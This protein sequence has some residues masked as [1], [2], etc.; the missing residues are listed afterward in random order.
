MQDEKVNHWKFCNFRRTS[1]ETVS[2]VNVWVTLVRA[3]ASQQCDPGSITEPAVI[4][5]L[6]LLLVGCGLSLLLVGLSLLF[7]YRP[8][9]HMWVEFVVSSRPCSS[10]KVP[11]TGSNRLSHLK[12]HCGT[13]RARSHK[14]ASLRVVHFRTFAIFGKL[15][16][17]L[18]IDIT[19]QTFS[20]NF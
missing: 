17:L 7:D 1:W 19:M 5:G 15:R 14:Y 18:E 2:L 4:C 3:L 20:T 10:L 6:S 11:Q 9:R 12:I 8:R 13:D 16:Q